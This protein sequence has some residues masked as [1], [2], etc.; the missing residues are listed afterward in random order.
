MLELDHVEVGAKE[1]AEVG[2]EIV[3]RFSD[4]GEG[5]II[6]LEGSVRVGGPDVKAA[7]GHVGDFILGSRVVGC[8]YG[9]GSNDGLNKV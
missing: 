9:T 3:T 1:G 8:I 2:Q 7:E 6:R 5:L 4:G